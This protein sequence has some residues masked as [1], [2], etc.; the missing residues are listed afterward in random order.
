M[1]RQ[2]AQCFIDKTPVHNHKN[3]LGYCYS[4][5]H[6]GY[7]N[8]R[9]IEEHGCLKK[10]CGCLKRFDRTYWHELERREKEKEKAKR[11]KKRKQ[12]EKKKELEVFNSFCK[13]IADDIDNFEAINIRKEKDIYIIRCVRLTS[14]HL[15][16]F[17]NEIKQK[18][19]TNVRVEFVKAEDKVKRAIIEKIKTERGKNSG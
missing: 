3:C 16:N 19:G 5:V 9:L 2:R 13:L 1:V 6:P 10:N 7:L 18:M 14:L 8:K 15:T 4:V 11:D 17:S 12:E